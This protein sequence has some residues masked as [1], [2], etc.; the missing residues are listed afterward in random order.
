MPQR[1]ENRQAAVQQKGLRRSH[2]T[3]YRAPRIGAGQA[4]EAAMAKVWTGPFAD[5]SR[6]RPLPKKVTAIEI[7][8]NIVIN[9]D[10]SASDFRPA[11]GTR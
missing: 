7:H 9:Q 11:E 3:L 2:S 10:S 4:L 1:L 5:A 6:S 8:A